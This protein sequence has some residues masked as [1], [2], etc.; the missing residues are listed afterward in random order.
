MGGSSIQ[1]PA[2]NP[3]L[4]RSIKPFSDYP[5]NASSRSSPNERG[6]G[7]MWLFN[8]SSFLM[9]H[10]DFWN[11]ACWGDFIDAHLDLYKMSCTTLGE[12]VSRIASDLSVSNLVINLRNSQ[13]RHPFNGRAPSRSTVP[14]WD[15]SA[16]VCREDPLKIR[17]KSAEPPIFTTSISSVRLS[18]S[19]VSG[20]LWHR[21][22]SSWAI[23]CLSVT[24]SSM[25]MR[26]PTTFQTGPTVAHLQFYGIQYTWGP[27]RG[28]SIWTDEIAAWASPDSISDRQCLGELCFCWKKWL[29]VLL[30][31]DKRKPHLTPSFCQIHGP[32]HRSQRMSGRSMIR[33]SSV[34]LRPAS[35]LDEIAIPVVASEKET[36]ITC[37]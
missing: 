34:I 37:F 11:A 12:V 27:G 1:K 21:R 7:S 3:R 16:R 25:Y 2:P 23:R 36:V 28:F 18:I 35:M 4:A 13:T 5:P 30:L 22:L 31:L 14:R 8:R 9:Q 33:P 24:R 29:W 10:A 17:W 20:L 6:N 15:I 32:M 26:S 19:L